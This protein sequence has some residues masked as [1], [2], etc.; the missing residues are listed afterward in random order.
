MFSGNYSIISMKLKNVHVL[1]GI[2]LLSSVLI[3]MCIHPGHDWGDDFALYISQ[4]KAI[5]NYSSGGLDTLYKLNKYCVEHSKTDFGPYL[6]PNGFPLLLTAIVYLK[7]INFISIKIF[8]AAFF[9]LSLP[10][11]FLLFNQ[12]FKDRKLVIFIVGCIAFH[13]SFLKFSD[14]VLSD[15]PFLFF[16]LL[17]IYLIPKCTSVVSQ[18]LL[19][20]LIFFTYSIRDIGIILLPTLFA[21]QW[22]YIFSKKKTKI[23]CHVFP[24]ITFAV[25]FLLSYFLLPRGTSNHFNMLFNSSLLWHRIYFNMIYYCNLMC[26]YFFPGVINLFLRISFLVIIAILFC[27]GA[28]YSFKRYL[29]FLVFTS[30]VFFILLIWVGVQGDRFIFPIIPFILFFLVKGLETILDKINNR[31]FKIIPFLYL[32]VLL[33]YGTISA[34]NYSYINLI[35]AV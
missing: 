12:S 18:I 23:S 4:A 25:F 28:I 7:G 11:I 27:L 19:G 26:L 31:Y 13:P 2:V 15:F 17:S 10:I 24:Y 35:S 8:C 5:N 1:L 34:V 20:I 33:G 9:I 6:Y 3:A 14:N 16:C 21:Y 22:Q 29:H 30:L 32:A